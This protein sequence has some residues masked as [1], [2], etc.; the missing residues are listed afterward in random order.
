MLQLNKRA[1]QEF[2]EGEYVSLCLTAVKKGDF[3]M[4]LTWF[5]VWQDN[6]GNW[7]PTL[8]LLA[9]EA[10]DAKFPQLASKIFRHRMPHGPGCWGIIMSNVICN[11]NRP[12]LRWLQEIY[13]SKNVD[14]PERE[15][16]EKIN[17]LINSAKQNA[18]RRNDA[19]TLRFCLTDVSFCLADVSFCAPPADPDP[20]VCASPDML[21]L[22]AHNAPYLPLEFIHQLSHMAQ[23]NSSAPCA[24]SCA[25]AKLLLK[26][27]DLNT[28]LH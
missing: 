11:R 21:W 3:E 28:P 2:A 24:I 13:R 6:D 22:V 10:L 23:P 1:W 16:K 20:S 15:F 5:A 18:L 14:E 9:T 27:L 25:M 26:Q 17:E 7:C 8:I 4:A 19:L 12:T